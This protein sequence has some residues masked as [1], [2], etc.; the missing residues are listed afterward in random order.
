MIPLMRPTFPP[1]A[2]AERVFSLALQNHCFSNFGPIHDRAV[3]EFSQ[4]ALGKAVFTTSGTTA[5]TLA[6]L[7]LGL[8]RGARIAVPD[9]THSGTLLS[10][11]QAGLTSVLMGVDAQTWVL[12]SDEVEEAFRAGLIDG[13]VVVSP[14]GYRVDFCAWDT[15]FE[16]TGLPMVYDLA[17]AFGE[18]P[19]TYAPRCYSFHST[20]N[21]GVGE[22]G[23]VVFRKQEDQIWARRL[24]NFDTLPDR[25]IASTI[26]FN[27]KIDELKAAFILAGLRPCYRAAVEKRIEA[28]RAALAFYER[29]LEAF[30]PRGVKYPSLCVL[31][32][33]PAA[34]LEKAGAAKNVAFKAYYPLLSHMPALE[35]TERLSES[36]VD[37]T[38]CCALPSDVT[39]EEAV[40]VVAVAKE[41]I[42]GGR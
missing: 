36:P 37:M 8:P 27:G 14:F 20:K 3:R 2:E 19:V 9:F 4:L 25:S 17:G 23:A 22:G 6:L 41:I 42:S 26:G 10:V 33:L 39:L 32:G 28:R 16:R 12:R 34:L 24:S 38:G 29:E 40:Q 1:F 11:V 21:F 35:K 15:I 13:A 18:F 31:G 7:T 30:V 5:L